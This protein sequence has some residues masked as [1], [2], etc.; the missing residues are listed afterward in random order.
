MKSSRV[1]WLSFRENVQSFPDSI[2]LVPLNHFSL[3][4]ALPFTIAEN[5]TLEPGM[6]SIGCSGTRKDGGSKR[7]HRNQT[8]WE[9]MGVQFKQNQPEQTEPEVRKV[10]DKIN[11][12]RPSLSHF[13]LLAR[14]CSSA[15][16]TFDSQCG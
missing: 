5:V 3:R 7:K 13:L 10:K 15:V 16:Q 6:A 1:T 12:N 4:G 14:K 11:I 2:S 8:W 9:K